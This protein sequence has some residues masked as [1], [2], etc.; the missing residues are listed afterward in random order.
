[1]PKNVEQARQALAK[2]LRDLRTNARLSGRELAARAGWHYT[3]ISKIEH[4]TTMPSE[5][6]LEC[7]QAGSRS[8]GQVMQRGPP[9]PRPSSSPGM[10]TTSMPCLSSIVLVATLR[11]YPTTTPGAS[12]R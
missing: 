8:I 12:A 2:R 3:K 1:M 5:A 6:D 7:R 11:S 4:G 10:V 9:R